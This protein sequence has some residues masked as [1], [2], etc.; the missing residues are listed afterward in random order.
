VTEMLKLSVEDVMKANGEGVKVLVVDSGVEVDHPALKGRHIRTWAAVPGFNDCDVV[1]DP[2]GKDA[3]GHGTAVAA[4]LH[5][6]APG[7]QIESLRVLGGNLR[8]SSQVVLAGLHWAI[9][10][11]YDVVNCSFGS[12]N[13][14]FLADY[15][16][17]IDKAFCRNVLIV[18]ACNNYDYKKL[19]YPGSFPTAISS[20]FGALEGLELQR[21]VG[22]LVEFVARGQDISVAWKDASYRISTGSSFAAPHLAAIVARIRQ[23]HPDWNV[24][25]MKAAL[26]QIGGQ[27][28]PPKKAEA[29]SA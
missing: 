13:N 22:E 28:P 5:E 18:S 4:I 3:F 1:D 2:E 15:K 26:Y 7:S 17:V 14:Q 24:C 25:Q 20:D 29:E 10:A 23:I 16:R 12:S 21:R 19:E 9:D 27:P 6:F 11:G 8:T